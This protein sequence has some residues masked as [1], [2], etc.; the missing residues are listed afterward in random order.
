MS[1]YLH[2]KFGTKL[3][4][5]NQLCKILT[6]KNQICL[7]NLLVLGKR[8]SVAGYCDCNFGGMRSRRSPKYN[9]KNRHMQIYADFFVIFSLTS[10]L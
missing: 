10:H 8:L 6:K 4:Q 7:H 5:K 3:Q 2:S 1:Y 9:T